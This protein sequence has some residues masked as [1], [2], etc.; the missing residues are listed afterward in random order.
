MA[1]AIRE[2]SSGLLT[3]DPVLPNLPAYAPPQVPRLV[4]RSPDN[5]WT[6]QV[7]GDRLDFVFQLP[8]EMLGQA[9]LA[10]TRR[11]QAQTGSAIWEALAAGFQAAGNRIGVVCVFFTRDLGAV[12]M[13]RRGFL[14]PSDAPEP[15]E[16]QI[17]ALH[18]MA[19]QDVTVNRWT[20]VAAGVPLR[21][22][23]DRDG[24]R[25]EIDVN[26][27]PETPFQVGSES[28]RGFLQQAEGVVTSTLAVLFDKD[29]P[30][31]KVF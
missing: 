30:G 29:Q 1:Q 16:L 4:L 14:Q 31:M 26:T 6:Y 3:A 19:L 23:H 25:V 24:L 22:D 5:R 12:G 28:V 13:L 18:R 9:T 11:I 20:R 10:E 17:H 21:G 2:A 7:R 8:P 27:L 15:H